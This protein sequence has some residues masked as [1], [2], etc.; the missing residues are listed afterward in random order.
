[1]V[2]YACIHKRN[3]PHTYSFAYIF[4]CVM[5]ASARTC[6]P[7]F[8]SFTD[9]ICHFANA[10]ERFSTKISRVAVG[11]WW[12]SRN[13]LQI[14]TGETGNYKSCYI[15]RNLFPESEDDYT[16]ELRNYQYSL[17]EIEIPR[18]YL[19]YT[20]FEHASHLNCDDI[21]RLWLSTK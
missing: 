7:L 12:W 15:K 1:M 8:Y 10:A 6:V 3:V 19:K 9:V 4:I 2:V 21:Y 13:I 17:N 5:H 18:F 20:W 11:R 16:N 14:I